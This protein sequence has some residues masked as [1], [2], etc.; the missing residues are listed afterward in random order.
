MSNISSLACLQVSWPIEFVWGGGL[1][2]LG[3][4]RLVRFG[5]DGFKKKKKKL[6]EFSI[7]V[8]GW[9]LDSLVFHQTW[10]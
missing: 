9:V 3:K 7:K 4:V 5:W 1:G 6:M 10:S 2:R 8:A